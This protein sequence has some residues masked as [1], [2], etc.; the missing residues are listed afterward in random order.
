[1]TELSALKAA[2]AAE[3][4]IVYGYGVVGAHLSGK[5]EKLASVLLTAHQER[6]DR[7]SALITSLGA[8]PP[9]ALPAYRLPFGVTDATTARQLAVVLEEGASGAAWDLVA[10][11]APRSTAREL[12][13]AWLSNTAVAT[14]EW[15]HMPAALPGAPPR[16]L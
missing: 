9:P 4:A 3:Q 11:S 5:E 1:M 6:R 15:G 7:L 2:L 10:A 12:A 8:L 14:S 16:P 13:V